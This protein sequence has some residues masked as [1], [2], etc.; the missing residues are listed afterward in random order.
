MERRV[1]SSE[2]AHCCVVELQLRYGEGVWCMQAEAQAWRPM[3]GVAGPAK[4]ELWMVSSPSSSSIAPLFLYGDDSTAGTAGDHGALVK[5][6]WQSWC[7]E[8]E[9][10]PMVRTWAQHKGGGPTGLVDLAL[11]VY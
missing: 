1:Q 11:G 10:S 2:K 6:H 8:A 3:L 9:Q 4:G 7:S 5:S